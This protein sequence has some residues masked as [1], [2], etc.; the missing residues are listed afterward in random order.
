MG[1]EGRALEEGADNSSDICRQL[2]GALR[3]IS[4]F[5]PLSLSLL[6][7]ALLHSIWDLSSP[8]RDGTSP[9]VLE[10]QSLKPLDLQKSPPW[11]S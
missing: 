3:L 5:F 8:T 10:V 11:F 4:P 1:W 6:F 2:L 7:L 9:T